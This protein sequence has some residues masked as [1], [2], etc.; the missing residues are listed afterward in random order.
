MTGRTSARKWILLASVAG[1]SVTAVRCSPVS[2]SVSKFRQGLGASGASEGL[3]P[4]SGDSGPLSR[5][6]A[7][8]APKARLEG[9][10]A[11]ILDLRS[12]EDAIAATK[13]PGHVE[14][15]PES[16]K[17]AFESFKSK[18][19][20]LLDFGT[21]AAGPNGC[22]ANLGIG[23]SEKEVKARGLTTVEVSCT[24]IAEG[25]WKFSIA[26]TL[27]ADEWEWIAHNLMGV[28]IQTSGAEALAVTALD[29]K[30]SIF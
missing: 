8:P 21:Q 13:S 19:A 11:R 6:A 16:H 24:H 17:E 20:V 10:S 23:L 2:P 28:T 30:Q 9:V 7:I 3:L 22:K 15:S 26:Q 14:L 1:L 25:V 18:K 12:Y 5:K 27:K 4:T 29:A